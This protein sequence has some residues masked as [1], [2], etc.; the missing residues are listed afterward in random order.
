MVSD[1]CSVID[2]QRVLLSDRSSANDTQRVMFSDFVFAILCSLL[3]GS[4]GLVW[5]VMSGVWCHDHPSSLHTTRTDCNTSSTESLCHHVKEN[6]WIRI[7]SALKVVVHK[8]RAALQWAGGD[9]RSVQNYW[10]HT[11]M[12]PHT[13][14]L[15]H[16][17]NVR[18]DMFSMF[19]ILFGKISAYV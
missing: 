7:R 10:N 19:V 6:R 11:K 17:W 15:L 8:E 2:A 4:F 12:Q 18:F 14:D 13:I 5:W 1:W 3:C 16:F 9:A